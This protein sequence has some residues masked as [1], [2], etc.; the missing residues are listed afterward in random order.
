M[1]AQ[2]YVQPAKYISLTS[3]RWK[4]DC[5]SHLRPLTSVNNGDEL[6]IKADEGT[7]LFFMQQVFL[8][9]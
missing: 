2:L 7:W 5:T 3:K 4:H 6:Q 1:A 8:F 9:Q